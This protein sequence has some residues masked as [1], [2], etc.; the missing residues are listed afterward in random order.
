MSVPAGSWLQ[1]GAAVEVTGRAE[2]GFPAS[3]SE[4]VVSS[5]SAAEASQVPKVEVKYNDV[6]G[7]AWLPT[8]GNLGLCFSR[9]GL[10]AGRADQQPARGRQSPAR[11]RRHA[12][13]AKSKSLDVV[14]HTRVA[15][16]WR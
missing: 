3:F 16:A 2:D 11:R 8:A 9:A 1:L 6:R 5:T 14:K 15:R 13:P 7:P 12:R 4:A 10:A